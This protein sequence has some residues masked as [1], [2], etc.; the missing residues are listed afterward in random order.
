MRIV[1]FLKK[2]TPTLGVH[3]GDTVIDL[4]IAAPHLPNDLKG[5]LEGGEDALTQVLPA[6]EAA[7]EEAK[8]SFDSITFLPPIT[9]SAKIICLG[10]NYFEHAEESGMEKPEFPT[11]F[12]RFGT[13]LVGH[14][15]PLIL[16]SCSKLLDYEAELVAIIGKK[17]KHVSREDAL[18]M[19]AGYTIF[20][21]GSVRD[22]QMRTTQWTMGKNF[23]AT[24]PCGPEFVSAD[25]LPPGA[26]GLNI[27]AR[28]NGRVLQDDNTE[29]MIFNVA[30]TI[31]ILTEGM[32]LLPGDILVMGTPSGVGFAQKPPVWMKAGDTVEIEIEEIG[33]LTNPVVDET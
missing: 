21:D 9:N 12:A 14:L 7:S 5:L 13:S 26:S 3:I 22:Y 4:S 11:L 30:E 18:S 10:L 29:N 19:V 23:D 24:G 8:T 31:A 6:A 28:L 25:E 2:Q 1:S 27:Q 16:P 15:Q 32:T 33:V 20:N 17:G